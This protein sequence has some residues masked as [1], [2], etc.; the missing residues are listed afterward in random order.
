[1]YVSFKPTEMVR[2]VHLIKDDLTKNVEWSSDNNLIFNTGKTKSILFGTRQ[3][4][5]T[6][7]LNDSDLYTIKAGGGITIERMSSYKVQRIILYRRL[8]MAVVHEINT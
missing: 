2:N 3:M 8:I 4:L 6:R 7:N 5:R 1:M